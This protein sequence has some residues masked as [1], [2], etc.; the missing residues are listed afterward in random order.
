MANNNNDSKTKLELA[1]D[2]ASKNKKSNSFFDALEELMLRI[3]RWFS[4]LIDAVVFAKKTLPAFAL[5]LAIFLYFAVTLSEDSNILT[6]LSSSKTLSNVQVNTLYNSNLFEVSGVPNACSVVLTGDAANVNNAASKAGYCLIDLQNISEG[7]H[8]VNLVAKG[9]GDNVNATVTPSQ[10]QITLKPK[11]TAEYDLEYAFNNKNKMDSR[12]ILGTP[13]FDDD[14][15]KINIRASKDTLDS[16]SR[17]VAQI[18]CSGR[19]ADFTVEAPLVAYDKDGKV[20][21]AEIVP[22]S[23]TAS[24]KVSSPNKIVPISLSLSGIAPVGYSIDSILMDHQTATIYASQDVLNSVSEV[25]VNLDL[26][27]ISGDTELAQSITLPNGVSASDVTMVNLTVKLMETQTKVISDI[28]IVYKNNTNNYGASNID[29]TMV[30]ITVSGTIENI[31]KFKLSDLNAY[32]DVDQLEPG[33]YELEI[34][35]ELSKDASADAIQAN[36]F[37]V[38]TPS[39]ATVNIT[40]IEG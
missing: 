27:T 24:V 16:I 26:S 31:S 15:G 8:T 12:Y 6:T 13:T 38:L 34:K 32:I 28:P 20:V 9:F 25:F 11:T 22:S 21:N 36:K 30:D 29:V 14:T 3:F 7:T 5:I 17:V 35:T 40:L 4:S 39:C 2:I 33:T 1:K 18:D 23:V 19:N 10:T 37:V